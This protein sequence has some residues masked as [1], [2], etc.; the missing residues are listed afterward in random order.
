VEANPRSSVVSA[1]AKAE[2]LP[3][4]HRHLE[5]PAVKDYETLVRSLIPGTATWILEQE[6]FVNWV[7]CV[8]PVLWLSGGPGCG[9]SHLSTLAIKHILQKAAQ[10][11]LRATSLGYYYF[12]DNDQRKQSVLSALCAIVYQ[13]ADRDEIYR[14]HAALACRRSPAIAMAT[15]DTVWKDFIVPEYGPQ[16]SGRLYLIF[17]GVDEAAREDIKEFISLLRDSLRDGLRAQVLFVGRPDMDSF[18]QKLDKMSMNAIEISSEMNA[19][20][21]TRFI[22]VKYD[23][24]IT[25][26]KVKGL[27]E[28]VITTLREKANGMFLWVDLMYQEL[29]EIKQ[30]KKLKLALENTST[31]L[32]ELYE[33]IL[34][35]V[36]TTKGSEKTLAQLR[37]IFC[38][39]AYSKEPLSIFYLNQIIQFVVV[40]NMFDAERNI[41]STCASLLRFVQAGQALFDTLLKLETPLEEGGNSGGGEHQLGELDEASESESEIDE[42]EAEEQEEERQRETFVHLRH[43]SLGDYV[44]TNDLKTTRILFNVREAK[45]H[46]VLT[47]LRIICEG[48][49][50]PEPLWLYAMENWLSQLGDLDERSVS[51]EDTKVIAEYIAK[52]FTS[53]PL[54]KFIAQHHSTYGGYPL[55]GDCFFFGSNAD[56]QNSNHSVIQKWLKKADGMKSVDLEPE[57]SKWTKEVLESPHR[58]LTPLSETC[59]REWLACDEPAIELYW[60]VRFVWQIIVSVG[61]PPIVNELSISGRPDSSAD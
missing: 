23:E 8:K 27:R 45:L 50:V 17:D 5:P 35:R 56:M 59:I 18:V 39:V 33:R 20:D 47:N 29:E 38:L 28:K 26:P 44:K 12:H 60:R 36:E 40:D 11:G 55:H 22:E 24:Y 3:T 53:E 52:I 58:L 57:S 2:D 32:R 34:T 16:S 48:P 19:E 54:G 6:A 21:I 41:K 30:P 51:P 25:I 31:G 10:Q 43:A 49:N 15:I 61:I 14:M 13:I 7:D 42:N 46:I 4:I 37:E 9:K 1:G